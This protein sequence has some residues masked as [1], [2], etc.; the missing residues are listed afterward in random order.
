MRFRM[1]LAAA[2][3]ALT[4]LPALAVDN[5]PWSIFGI[6][7]NDLG[8]IIPW[9]PQLHAYGYHAAAQ[10]HC[11]AYRRIAHI[12]S[13]HPRYGEYVGFECFLPRSDDP[14]RAGRWWSSPW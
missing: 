9:S 13:V 1:L 10:R 5:E 11:D 12:T 7:G 6:L 4:T 2:A 14:V 3:L 8:G